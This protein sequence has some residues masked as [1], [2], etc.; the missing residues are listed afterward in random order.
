MVSLDQRVLPPAS[1][2]N[3]KPAHSPCLWREDWLPGGQGKLG[4]GEL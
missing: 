2:L 4:R 1:L 3:V